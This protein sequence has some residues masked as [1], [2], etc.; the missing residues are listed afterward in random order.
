VRRLEIAGSTS[1]DMSTGAITVMVV[2]PEMLPDLAVIVVTPI[3][4]V[5]A[6]PFKLAALLI[7]AT[8]RADEVQVTDEVI[9]LIELS[10]KVP[11]AVN[12]SVVPR[13]MLG[14]IGV[15]VIDTSVGEG[16]LDPPPLQPAVR[17]RISKRIG[18]LLDFIGGYSRRDQGWYV[19]A[20]A[21]VSHMPPFFHYD[22]IRLYLREPASRLSRS[23]P[24]G[25]LVFAGIRTKKQCKIGVDQ[26]I[27]SNAEYCPGWRYVLPN[28]DRIR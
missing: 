25:F 26:A 13:A 19:G 18:I 3:E 8:L 22:S 1:I 11:L 17:T 27:P 28:S 15:I 23:L 4:T 10:E 21:Q 2:K 7:V 9:F 24:Q 14:F 20:T 16:A 12:C 6:K 5:V